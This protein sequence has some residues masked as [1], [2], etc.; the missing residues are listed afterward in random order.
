LKDV[1]KIFSSLTLEMVMIDT[2]ISTCDSL[3]SEYA[4]LTDALTN[5]ITSTVCFIAFGIHKLCNSKTSNPDVT[6][7][8]STNATLFLHRSV[9]DICTAFVDLSLTWSEVIDKVNFNH[10]LVITPSTR[11][12]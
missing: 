9:G 10:S 3:K 1:F 6:L 2:A 12:T 7:P 4:L 11:I 8:T 5:C